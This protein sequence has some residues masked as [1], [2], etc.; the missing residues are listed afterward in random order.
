MALVAGLL[1]GLMGWLVVAVPALVAWVADPLSS[2]S[3]WLTLGIAADLWALAHGGVVLTPDA[4]VRLSPLLLTVVPVLLTRYAVRQVLVEPGY[5]HPPAG[6]GGVAAAWSALRATEL[7]SFVGGYVLSGL[8]IALLAG[9]GQASVSILSLL[10]G[11]IWVP[12]LGIALAMMREHRRQEHPTI[13]RALSWVALRTPMLVRRGLAPAAEA[14]AG[15][16]V[17]A[18]LVV[19]ALVVLRIGRVWSLTGALEAGWV[20]VAVLT[21]AQL[22][23]LPNLLIWALGW[24]TGA[25][26]SVGTVRIG[27]SG[28]TGGDLPLVPVLAALP[29]PGPFPPGM[30][31]VVLVPVGAGVWLGWRGVR[32][33]ARLSSWWSKAQVALASCGMVAGVV[34]VLAW[35]ASG[36]LSPGLLAV[37]GVDPVQVAA[38]LLGELL[39]GSGVMVTALHLT[40]RRL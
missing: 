9:L 29:E 37:V 26:A 15:L 7:L 34:L 23:L 31:L 14:L 38:V 28:T 36:G 27:W 35:L 18:L 32:S 17:A 20:G 11:L 25:G 21:V 4:S 1:A 19:I 22:L 40:R 33:A 8:V 3:M 6:I 2:V 10:P 12:L 16:M 30:W 13:D 39:L 5:A 24:L